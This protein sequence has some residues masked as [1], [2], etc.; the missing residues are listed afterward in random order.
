MLGRGAAAVCGH[1]PRGEGRAGTRAVHWQRRPAA[2][3]AVLLCIRGVCGLRG[4]RLPL[5][6]RRA[7][8]ALRADPEFALHAGAESA[9]AAAAPR[10]GGRGNRMR[11]GA[12]VRL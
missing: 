3:A 11:R 10:A 2:G 4:G 7:F 9:P 8:E 1:L 12:P 5:R 6:H